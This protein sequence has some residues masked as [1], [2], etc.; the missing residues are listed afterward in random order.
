MYFFY[1]KN[2]IKRYPFYIGA[3]MQQQK[4]DLFDMPISP[5]NGVYVPSFPVSLSN[6][7]RKNKKGT[8]S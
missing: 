3:V 6:L 1:G 5:C 4:A 7:Q 2:D 8:Q